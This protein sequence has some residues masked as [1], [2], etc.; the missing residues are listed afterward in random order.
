M[1]QV[2]RISA[3]SRRPVTGPQSRDRQ[4]GDDRFV[5]AGVVRAGDAAEF[6]AGERGASDAAKEMTVSWAAAS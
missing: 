5:L 4:G 1:P 3:D 6:V 2:K